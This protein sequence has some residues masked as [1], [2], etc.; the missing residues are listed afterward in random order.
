MKMFFVQ[1]VERNCQMLSNKDLT[2]KQFS[3][4]F[5]LKRMMNDLCLVEEDLR[6]AKDVGMQGVSG[7][8]LRSVEMRMDDLKSAVVNALKTVGI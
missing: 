7:G 1:S 2:Q 3:Y 8:A 5:A 6:Q 4:T